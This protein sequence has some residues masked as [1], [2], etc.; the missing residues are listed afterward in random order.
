[1]SWH[2]IACGS[3]TLLFRKHHFTITVYLGLV[4]VA[5]ACQLFCKLGP[6]IKPRNGKPA[7]LKQAVLFHDLSRLGLQEYLLVAIPLYF[8]GAGVGHGLAICFVR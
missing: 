2:R 6:V 4:L 1:M 8:Q 3:K 5:D 7:E